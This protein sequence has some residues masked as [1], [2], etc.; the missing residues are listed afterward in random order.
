MKNKIENFLIY[1]PS[2]LSY[3]ATIDELRDIRIKY[4]EY[5]HAI[6]T[7]YGLRIS[8][9]CPSRTKKCWGCA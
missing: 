4:P 7:K 8:V 5:K 1:S 6:W 9:K 3:L 2:G